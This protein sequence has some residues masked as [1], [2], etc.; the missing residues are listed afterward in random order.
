M[1][2]PPK[3]WGDTDPFAEIVNRAL[4]RAKPLQASTADV[5]P[6]DEDE[7][8]EDSE[9]REAEEEKHEDDAYVFL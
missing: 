2:E 7:Q 1:A 4:L 6:L 9:Q 3:P 8:V 5:Q